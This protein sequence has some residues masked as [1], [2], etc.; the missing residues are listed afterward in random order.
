MGAGPDPFVRARNATKRYGD[1]IAVQG[2]TLDVAPG[3]IL[4]I[5]GPSGSGKTTAI[6]M[7]TGVTAPT[8]GDVSVFGVPPTAFK[9]AQRA[10]LGYMPQLS[11]LFPHLSLHEN[12]NFVASIY[13]LTL[14]RRARLREALA[15]VGL[16]GDRRKQ[17]R[18]TSGGM[19]RRLALAATLL[20][21]PDL[22][23]PDEPTVGIDPLLRRKF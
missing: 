15:F 9:P 20:H 8:E 12:L 6:R 10:R 16:E 14:R 23:F 21:Q 13:G 3:T 22:L 1:E 5:V 7:L 11:V 4:G 17:L 18:Q 19:Q 2:L